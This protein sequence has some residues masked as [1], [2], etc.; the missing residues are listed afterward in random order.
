MAMRP[1]KVSINRSLID[2]EEPRNKLAY[3]HDW[4]AIELSH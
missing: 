1:L 4:E 2:K 3:S